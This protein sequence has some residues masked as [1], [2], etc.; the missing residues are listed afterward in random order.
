MNTESIPIIHGHRGCRGLMPENSLPAFLHAI[1][2]GC[3]AI[4]MDVVI[5]KDKQVVISHEPFISKFIC[6]DANNKPIPDEQDKQLNIYEM[7]YEAVKKYDCGSVYHSSFVNQQKM[8]VYKPTLQEVID[9]VTNFCKYRNI[10]S[11]LY[12]IEIKSSTEDENVYQPEVNEFADLVLEVIE[13]NNI[14]STCI[15][16]SFD[17]RILQS[18]HKKLP[19]IKLAYLFKTETSV[20]KCLDILKFKPDYLSPNHALINEPFVTNC[21]ENNLG[22]LAWTVNELKDLEKMMALNVD[23]IITDYPN[24]AFEILE[25]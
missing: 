11:I 23:G 10:E 9:S 24:R 7:D 22:V 20:K 19:A 18:I 15:I 25:K 12:N 21:R 8:Q 13:N 3:R 4:E 5:S 6:L 1:E 14:S 2:L 17:E 16:Q